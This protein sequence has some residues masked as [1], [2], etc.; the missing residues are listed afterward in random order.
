MADD[1][2]RVWIFNFSVT[3]QYVQ[4][5]DCVRQK[6]TFHHVPIHVKSDWLNTL[7]F[8]LILAALN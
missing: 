1:M 3:L 5:Y 2:Q 4:V 7:L 6:T 8:N